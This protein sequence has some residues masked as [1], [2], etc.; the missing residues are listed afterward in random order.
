M[1]W[2]DW[3]GFKS[4]RYTG[5]SGE[6]WDPSGSFTLQ[7]LNVARRAG[8]TGMSILE[9]MKP[10]GDR[11][12]EDRTWRG[13]MREGVEAPTQE[14]MGILRNLERTELGLKTGYDKLLSRLDDIPDQPDLSSYAK[15][16]DI[17]ELG[18]Y[19]KTA[20]LIGKFAP[21][22]DFDTARGDITKLQGVDTSYGTRI[23]TLENTATKQT[24]DISDAMNEAMKVRNTSASAV[25]NQGIPIGVQQAQ[26]PSAQ[27]GMISAGLAGLSRSNRKFRNK[28]LNIGSSV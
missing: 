12:N 6:D 4:D 11:D 13:A 23:G 20:D 9:W 14:V 19:A 3:Y 1:S 21:K 22:T 16:S 28:T 7:N 26:S 17:P 8:H 10:V 2:Q 24:K 27:A 15:K 5:P 18:A 25:Q